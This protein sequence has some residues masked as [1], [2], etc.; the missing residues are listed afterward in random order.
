[1]SPAPEPPTGGPAGIDGWQA[2]WPAIVDAVNRRDPMLAGVLRSC[3][4]LEA[5]AGR[6]VVGAPYGFHLERLN[7]RQ[8][9][10]LLDEVISEVAGVACTV[11]AVFSGTEPPA[12]P[13][14]PAESGAPDVTATVLAT[15]PGSRITASRLRDTATDGST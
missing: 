12:R 2:L 9:A 3:R 8:K 14:P 15:F 7:E 1:V 13:A 10:R 4:P 6:L 5:P 11:E